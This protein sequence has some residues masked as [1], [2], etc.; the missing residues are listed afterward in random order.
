MLES[1]GKG[2]LSAPVS[3]LNLLEK[4]GVFSMLP[5]PSSLGNC[6]L[7]RVSEV[8]AEVQGK[9]HRWRSGEE[10]RRGEGG[11][12]SRVQIPR[13]LEREFTD[14]DQPPRKWRLRKAKQPAQ[15]HTAKQGPLKRKR[16]H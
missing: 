15:V 5:C 2:K 11:Q 6:D 12:G 10:K 8:C 16:R 7:D 13:A 3:G 1:S 4:Q 14:P 9:Q